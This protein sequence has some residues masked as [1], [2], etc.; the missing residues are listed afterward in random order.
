MMVALP[1]YVYQQTGSTLASAA[2]FAAFYLPSVLL[3]SV[4]GVFADRWDRKRILVVTSLMQCAVMLLLLLVQS[5]DWLWLVYVVLFVETCI[6][7]F[8]QPAESALLPRL[9]DEEQLVTANT[10]NALNNNIARLVGPPI[11]GLLIAAFGLSSVALVDS[12]SFLVAAILIWL[13]VGSDFCTGEPHED[14]RP[15][16]MY[17]GV[18]R[19]WLEGLS[20]VRRDHLVAALFTVAAVTSFGGCMFDPL[21]SPWV[22]SILHGDALVQGWL[23]TAGAIGG[24]LGGMLLGR[25]SRRTQPVQLFAFSC[26]TAGALLLVMYNLTWIPAVLTLSLVKSVPLVGSGVALTTLFQT[27]VPDKYLGRVSGSVNTTIALVGLVSLGLAGVLGEM[28]GIV[29]MLSVAA[30]ITALAGMLA[31]VL[32]PARSD[33][34]HTSASI[35]D[36]N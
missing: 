27:S 8:F 20:L 7:M 24:L 26:I 23:A 3:G 12:V 36:G 14:E 15:T 19:E 22:Q 31:L 4:A 21:I 17:V 13:M 2:M 28:V 30:G 25:F 16:P 29:P 32:L 9:V 5:Q 18:W 35:S 34:L 11:G 10:L 33:T 1:F 6:S